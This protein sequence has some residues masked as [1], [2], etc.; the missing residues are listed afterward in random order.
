VVAVFL[1]AFVLVADPT[2]PR[3][4]KSSWLP[5][6][7]Y[8][9]AVKCHASNVCTHARHLS[10]K[11]AVRRTPAATAL[12]ATIIPSERPWPWSVSHQMSPR[13]A[14]QI[15]PRFLLST[16]QDSVCGW[17]CPVT[18]SVGQDVAQHLLATGIGTTGGLIEGRRGS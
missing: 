18:N 17:V 14:R 10:G 16:I 5:T 7:H 8:C 1:L 15:V 2:R 12:R 11:Y 3:P 4:R 13:C 9:K 6:W